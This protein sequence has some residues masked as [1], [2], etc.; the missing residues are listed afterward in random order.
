MPCRAV[1]CSAVKEAAEAEF[2]LC[3]VTLLWSSWLASSPMPEQRRAAAEGQRCDECS[4]ERSEEVSASVLTGNGQSLV[5]LHAP[6]P[7][8]ALML[9]QATLRSHH[10]ART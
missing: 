7:V 9:S 6:L 3:H 1:Q 2:G 4:R 10:A 8:P 5:F